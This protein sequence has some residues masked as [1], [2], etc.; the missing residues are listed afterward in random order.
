V[1]GDTNESAATTTAASKE[2][3]LTSISETQQC[4]K[5]CGDRNPFVDPSITP[6]SATYNA[7]ISSAGSLPVLLRCTS[8]GNEQTTTPNGINFSLEM[9]ECCDMTPEC[10]DSYAASSTCLKTDMLATI[11]IQAAQYLHCLDEKS[12]SGE[13]GSADWCIRLLTGGAGVGEEN[14]FALTSPKLYNMTRDATTCTDMAPFLVDA[15][16][17]VS[18]CCLPCQPFIAKVVE[19]VTNDL[20]LPVYNQPSLQCPDMACPTPSP[21]T[22]PVEVLATAATATPTV[23]P[24]T[25]TATATAIATPNQRELE[26]TTTVHDSNDDDAI[27]GYGSDLVVDYANEC[28]EEMALNIVVYNETFAVDSFFA[29][30]TQKMGNIIARAEYD[31]SMSSMATNNGQQGGGQEEVDAAKEDTESSNS[32]SSLN[33]FLFC[34]MATASLMS[35]LLFL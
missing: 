26:G 14:D 18:G 34:V 28:N 5:T 25:T 3:C 19:A 9:D 23:V 12:R 4:I 27:T 16:T 20:L 7:I 31:D 35:S 29:C 2:A 1:N 13:C 15:C 30:L 6:G 24:V 21:T 33:S 22:A 10:I 11:Q 32:S 8:Q 17:T